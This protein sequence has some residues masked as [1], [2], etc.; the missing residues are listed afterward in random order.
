MN[1]WFAEYNLSED[2]IPITYSLP[3]NVGSH[4]SFFWICYITV[5][6]LGVIINGATFLLMAINQNLQKLA[7][8]PLVRYLVAEDFTFSLVCLIQCC[9][10]YHSQSLYGDTTGCTI[11]A[12][13]VCFF[14][15]ITGYTLCLISYT[16]RINVTSL[17]VVTKNPP[18]FRIHLVFWTVGVIFA[19]F[20]TYWPGASRMTLSGTY[21]IPAYEHPVPAVFFFGLAIFPTCVFLATQYIWIFVYVSRVGADPKDKTAQKHTYKQLKL[22]RQ[23]GSLVVIYFVFYVPF[24]C[25]AIY[26]WSTHYY[27]VV[28][29]DLAG[30]LA[31]IASVANPVMYLWMTKQAKSEIRRV[32]FTQ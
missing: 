9:L 31:H 26:E 32:V 6:V 8:V 11:E 13:Q 5:L 27:A 2:Q 16:M 10:N 18:I 3:W 30:V 4:Y 7:S 1:N 23:L 28:M 15:T 25:S 19:T 12:W 24:L 22:A 17:S 20:A 29:F 21:C 14:I